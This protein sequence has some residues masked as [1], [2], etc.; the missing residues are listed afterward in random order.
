M[1]LLSSLSED[2]KEDENNDV[3]SENVD[4][5]D[6][7]EEYYNDDGEDATKAGSLLWLLSS[8]KDGLR[9]QTLHGIDKRRLAS[10]M[11][12]VQP[13]KR[14]FLWRQTGGVAVD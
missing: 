10:I 11:P 3:N 14:P 4:G 9:N 8:V 5:E 6:E 2:D 13:I 1:L 7:E 12:I